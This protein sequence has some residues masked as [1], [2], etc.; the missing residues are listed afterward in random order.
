[1][2]NKKLNLSELKVKSF[3]TDLERKSDLTIR[4]GFDWIDVTYAGQ[5]CA[6]QLTGCGEGTTGGDYSNNCDY[7]SPGICQEPTRAGEATCD[8][9]GT[10]PAEHPSFYC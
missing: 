5:G 1:M 10:G 3:V 7:S 2:K 8:G 4:G 6:T 9:W